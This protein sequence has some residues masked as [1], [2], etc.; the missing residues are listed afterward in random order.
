VTKRFWKQDADKKYLYLRK[1][2]AGGWRNLMKRIFI[3]LHINWYSTDIIR[4]YAMGW[5]RRMREENEKLRGRVEN[6]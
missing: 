6:L 2:D 1:R 4:K 3:I 5:N